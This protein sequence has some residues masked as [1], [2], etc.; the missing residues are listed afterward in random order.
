MEGNHRIKLFILTENKDLLE[1]IVSSLFKDEYEIKVYSSEDD[2][3]AA[4][5]KEPPELVISDLLSPNINGLDVCRELRKN[6]LFRYVPVILILP[7]GGDQDKEKLIYSGVDDYIQKSA[8]NRELLIK[9]KL[10][11][12]RIARQQDI[13]PLT[14]LPGQ[15][16]LLKE[17]QKR[18]E[19]KNLF[20]LYYADLYKIREFNQRYGF[21][22]G[23]EVIKYAGQ[24][25]FKSLRNFGSPSDFLSHP[26]NDD[27][28]FITL[29]DTV[30]TVGNWITSEF[31]KNV[32]AFYDAEDVKRGNI[33]LKN[34]RGEIQK[35]PFLR[36]YIGVVTNEHYAFVN[37]GQLIQVATELRNF[38][39]NNF[40]K[41]IFVKD[42]RKSYSL[43]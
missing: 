40:Q 42:R 18:I 21:K 38:A 28:I 11:L 37:P 39:Q 14:R 2:A 25:I 36:I 10:N 17:L 34:R 16:S 33:L 1:S 5:E 22:R 24:L 23:D 3:I 9:I 13:N 43:H 27:F 15:S 35:T 41:S 4:S 8:V 30:E 26:Q 7:D 20:A 31:D 19:S 6:F 12:F 32:T 29:P